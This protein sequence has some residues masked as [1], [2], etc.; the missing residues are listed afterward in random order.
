MASPQD[1]IIA[2]EAKIDRRE[3]RRDQL[4][5]TD[6]MYVE[7]DIVLTREIAAFQEEKVLLIRQQCKLLHRFPLSFPI[8]FAVVLCDQI[9]VYGFQ[10]F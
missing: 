2:L 7:H 10:M 1:R 3:R 8:L 5:T 4:K 6:R 9:L